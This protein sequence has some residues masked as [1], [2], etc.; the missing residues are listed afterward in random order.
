MRARGCDGQP[1]LLAHPELLVPR[2]PYQPEWELELFEVARV[3]R[4]LAS[5]TWTRTVSQNGQVSLGGTHYNLGRKWAEQT[6]SVSFD[7]T[8]RQL[9]FTQVR[10][11]SAA[12]RRLAALAPVYR[13]AKGLSL[14]DLTGLPVALSELPEHQLMFP[15]SMCYPEPTRQAA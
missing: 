6:V 14:E 12:G 9:V 3:H 4:Y 11:Q 1:P 2:R 7:A 10:A 8:R 15:L 13:D 5:Q